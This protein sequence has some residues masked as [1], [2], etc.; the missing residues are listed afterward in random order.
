MALSAEQV[1]TYLA[2]LDV[3]APVVAQLRQGPD[4]PR[5][6]AA[7]TVLQRRQLAA[8]PLENLDLVYSSAHSL[9]TETDVVFRNIVHRKRGGV[10]DQVHVLFAKLLRS[11][12]FVVYCTGGRL[13]AA[14]GLRAA[15]GMDASEPSFGPWV[16]LNTI[17][18]IGPSDYLVDTSH[19]P[20]GSP[21]PVR[22]AH[23]EPA[24]DMW[25]RERRLVH[26]PLPGCAH[27]LQRWWRLQ[28]RATADAP[29]MDVWAFTE[30]EWLFHDFEMLRV[31]YARLGTSWAAPQPACFRTLF[32]D[33]GDTPVGYD[34]MVGDELRRCYKGK[35]QVTHKFYAEQ[36]R[37]DALREVFGIELTAEE[38]GQI[39]GMAAELKDEDFDYYG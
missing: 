29:W 38:Q 4:G 11:F 30:T 25:P 34:L 27:P 7:V 23:D 39:A 1:D 22:L 26:G 20:S 31:A 12:G 19:G 5:A 8:V 15:P 36:D 13:N 33:D 37:V 9:P 28:I 17:V 32:E 2:Y 18:T 21:S 10:C 14:A 16:H 35:V 24:V 6:L 3:P